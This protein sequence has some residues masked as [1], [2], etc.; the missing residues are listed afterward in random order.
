VLRRGDRILLCHRAP[1]RE[2]Y[3]GKWDLPG[4]HIEAG[5]TPVEALA[6]ELGEEMGIRVAHTAA[7][8]LLHVREEDL[9]LAILRVAAWSGEPS[10]IDRAEHDAMRW[11]SYAELQMLPLVDTRL[12]DLLTSLLPAARIHLAA[13]LPAAAAR[14]IEALRRRWDPVMAEVVPAHLTLAYPEEAPDVV[15]LRTRAGEA[16]VHEVPFRMRLA[17]VTALEG[18]RGGCSCR[19]RIP[20]GD[21]HAF[22]AGCSCRRSLP[23]IWRRTSRS[24]T[25]GRPRMGWPPSRRCR[26]TAPTWSSW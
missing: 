15:L 21:G 18:G 3:P 24:L 19:R 14:P 16:A 9:D 25:H 20:T 22:G 2:W 11:C 23:G 1:S 7:E 10:I 13:V 26:A 17:A 8:P 6:R 5:E 12:A 4:G